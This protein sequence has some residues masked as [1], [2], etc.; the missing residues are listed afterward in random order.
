MNISIVIRC[1]DDRR[2]FRC[3]ESIDEKAD[4]VAAI[5]ENAALQK[6]LEASNIRYCLTP[7]G[8]LSQ[9]SN[10]G[11]DAASHSKVI[12]TDSDT[13]FE[14]GCIRRMSN[15]LDDRRIVRA[16]LSFRHDAVH[17]LSKV[18]AEARD[19]VNALPLVY[20][21]GI[22]VRKDIIPDIGGFLFNSPVPYAVDADLN[23]RIKAA[24]IPVAFLK[25]AVLYHD[26]EWLWHDLKAAARIGK[27]CMVS[28]NCLSGHSAFGG[29]KKTIVKRLKGVKTEH[30]RRLL[31]SKGVSV[32]MYQ[33]LWDLCF[34]TGRNAEWVRQNLSNGKNGGN[35]ALRREVQ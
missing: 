33:F 34:Y 2:I 20:T 19:F 1:G 4:I 7:R 27:G 23:Y 3:V 17:P 21:P 24:G 11:F 15:A 29:P 6:E 12:I 8:N 35:G 16:R 10:L 26:A 30:W 28:A 18:V 9:T 14:K 13:V 32:M 25:D 31:R 22:G 5:S